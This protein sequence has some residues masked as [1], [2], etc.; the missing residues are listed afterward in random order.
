MKGIY[1]RLGI[2]LLLLAFASIN[3]I[4]CGETIH[5]AG[6]DVKRMGKGVK[7]FFVREANE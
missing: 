1:M 6:K 4:G 5:G 7:T 2:I 3:I